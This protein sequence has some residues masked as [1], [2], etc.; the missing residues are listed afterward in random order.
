[1]FHWPP[2]ETTSLT[3]SANQTLTSCSLEQTLLFD[4][5]IILSLLACWRC[6]AWFHRGSHLI[7]GLS[8]HQFFSD[9]VNS[10]PG[11]TL[12]HRLFLTCRETDM[13]KCYLLSEWASTL[14]SICSESEAPLS[15]WHPTCL[16]C[17]CFLGR[18]STSVEFTASEQWEHSYLSP[19]SFPRSPSL[20]PYLL[21]QLYSLNSLGW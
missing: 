19:P 8:T 5:G 12:P 10:I 2:Y 3:S 1:M 21:S 11:I 17:W 13:S 16:G 9:G 6:K 7:L 14:P 20:P 15:L 4:L 18:M